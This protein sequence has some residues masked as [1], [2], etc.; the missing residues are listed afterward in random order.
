[1]D[2]KDYVLLIGGLLV[3]L[4]VIYGI[5]SSWRYKKDPLKLHI[6][7]NLLEEEADC[8]QG[9]DAE[10]PNGGSRLVTKEGVG[11]QE[12][13]LSVQL[14]LD[15]VHEGVDLSEEGRIPEI[16]DIDED[17][18]F[19]RVLDRKDDSLALSADEIVE[20]SSTQFH[21]IGTD[22]LMSM[23]TPPA[24]DL[25]VL[26]VT[27]REKEFSGVDVFETLKGHRLDFGEM[28]I[29][30]KYDEAGAIAYSI[31]N[32]AEP[33][34]FDLVEIE[35]MR[36]QGLCFFLQLPGPTD[37]MRAVENM[38]ETSKSVSIA[39]RG[40]VKDEQ[41]NLLTQQM[42]EHYRQRILDHARRYMSKRA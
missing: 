23:D 9:P 33:G 16:A 29:F 1:M 2:L 35:S 38:L 27:A 26:Y 22:T 13:D 41:R 42:V 15:P 3:G 28:N 11:E 30:H 17:L 21:E 36:L 19:N 10:L 5:F 12:H 24:E 31:A 37:P 39:L 4:V 8:T 20:E 40:D 18:D 14:L 7:P 34:N 32:I 25:I 6:E